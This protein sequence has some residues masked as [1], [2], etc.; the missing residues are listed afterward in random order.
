MC[1]AAL[2]SRICDLRL[3]ERFR[4]QTANLKSPPLLAPA[5]ACYVAPVND[6]LIGLLGALMATNQPSAVSNLML[7]KTGVSISVPDKNDPVEKEFAKL[8]A[9]DNAAQAEVDQWIQRSDKFAEAGAGRGPETLQARI[10]QRFDSVKKAYEDF[11][12]RY[13]NHARAHLAYGSFL[14]DI[15]EENGAREQWEKGR[16]LDPKNPAAWNNLAN[17]YGHNSPVTK[18]FEYYAK[19]IELNPSESVYYQNFATTVYLFRRDAT[20]YFNITESE[21][22]DKALAL[23][24]K[25]LEL[26]PQNFILATDLAQSYYGIK[27]TRTGDAEADRKTRERLNEEAM[28]AW[29]VALKLARDDIERQG[30]YIHF[31]RLNIDAGRFD[32]ARKNLNTVT[33]AMFDATKKTLTK[34]L[35]NQENKTKGTN[36]PA[37]TSEKSGPATAR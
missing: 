32:E 29:E 14:N 2:P 11:L 18:A 4:S 31:A 12:Q 24:R 23:Y 9:D 15:G 25:A 1:L 36:A 35:T 6:L 8:M 13:P 37:A 26:D 20:N 34:K 30:V 7:K 28:A 33:N 21:V 17:W 19:A 27:Q 22:F 3:R 5:S 10:K 16:E